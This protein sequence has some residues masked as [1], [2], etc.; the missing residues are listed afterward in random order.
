MSVVS[1]IKSEAPKLSSRVFL[2]PDI[3]EKYLNNAV[4]SISDSKADP[5]FV[6]AVVDTSL[7]NSCKAGVLFT[8][9][10]LFFKGSL[11]SSIQIK[12]EDISSAKEVIKKE[13][14]DDGSV[15]ELKSLVILGK[16]GSELYN[17]YDIYDLKLLAKI[18][19]E[20]IEEGLS[21]DSENGGEIFK[22]TNQVLPLSDCESVIK[23]AYIKIICNYALSDDGI[24]DSR[25]YSEIYSIM[26]RN[27]Y[28]NED[29]MIARAYIT[30]DSEK[31]SVDSLLSVLNENVPE[32]SYDA[33][34]KSIVKDLVYINH[35][36]G[37]ELDSW[38][39]N[40]FIND[41]VKKLDV[42]EEQ[43]E[44]ITKSIQNDED[45]IAKRKSDTEIEKSIKEIAAKGASV[46]VPLA[47]LYF[48]GTVGFSAAGITSG[49][50]TLGMGGVLGF[51]S[52]VTGIGVVVITG[53][54]AYNGVKKLTGAKEL[55]NN[56]VR[57]ML[58]QG[59]IK[60]LQKSINYLIEDVN[61]ISSELIQALENQANDEEK[62]AKL[63][64]LLQTFIDASNISSQ[65]L[66]VNAKESIIAKL[67][68]KLDKTRFDEITSEP[69][70]QKLRPFVYQMYPETEETVESGGTK[71]T[72]KIYKIDYSK[73]TEY[74]EKLYQVLD[75]LEYF[76]LSTAVTAAGASLA[77]KGFGALKNT[78]GI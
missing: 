44:V 62:I 3:P 6:I 26:V 66:L 75:A 53:V 46:G 76:K 57:E 61:Y 20:I 63:K 5:D 40:D 59:V 51:S 38:K 36:K 52:M 65:N 74:Y 72:I 71:K 37:N 14:K 34:K 29:R 69:T 47:A 2:A 28:S 67:P 68:I 16:D 58:I 55:E 8:G 70:K 73:E 18:I 48:S 30:G 50:A 19:T 56:K 54:L 17:K 25:E 23:Q 39:N 12:Y 11:G 42:T 7:L 15:I 45:I 60:N 27:D 31:D 13:K 21:A 33:L 64:K 22:N 32:G 9:D 49:L 78:L 35:V 43:I 24:I 4:L 41:T 10:S 77:K 1:I